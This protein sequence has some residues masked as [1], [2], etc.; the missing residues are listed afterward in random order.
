MATKGRIRMLLSFSCFLVLMGHSYSQRDKLLQG[1]ELKDGDQLVSASRNFKLEFFTPSSMRKSSKRYI[2]V[3]YNKP[4]DRVKFG[5]SPSTKAVWVANRNIPILDKSASLRIDSS[6]GNLKIFHDGENPIQ[7][8]WVQ[9]ARNTSVTLLQTGN[10]VLH[11]THLNGSIKHVLWQSFDYPTDT[12]LPGMKVGINL[13]TGHQWFL[14][15]WLT[16]DCPAQGRY[17]V[18]MDQNVTNQL[19]V[20]RRGQVDRTSGHLLNGQFKS[21]DVRGYK[22]RYISNEREK[23]ISYS[24]SED[25]TSYPMLAIDWDGSLIDDR[26]ESIGSCSVFHEYCGSYERMCSS[27]SSYFVSTIGLM[28]G[29]GIK[30]RESDNMTLD[31][32]RLKCFKN[33]FCVAYAA[34]NP[35]NDTGCEVWSRGTEFIESYDGNNREIHME[36]IPQVIAEK[37][38]KKW[39]IARIGLVIAVALAL[40]VILLCSLSYEARRKYK[41]KE[42]NTNRVVGTYGYMSPEYAM[43]GIVSTKTDPA[44]FINVNSDEDEE[45]SE[46]KLENCSTNDVTIS[47]MEAR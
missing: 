16:D 30:F 13:Q 20:W 12:L 23:Y 27:V 38:E 29:S 10:L 14:Q 41:G 33:C 45:V 19:T 9:G 22:F 2:G 47:V 1:E 18:G 35:E 24:V 28:S 34:T 44:F 11:E 26:G 42:A 36:F 25:I 5:S 21:W 17:T 43:S 3:W 37:K 4:K 32:C 6:D 7:I 15:S 8:S 39:W 46:I 31:D 40:L